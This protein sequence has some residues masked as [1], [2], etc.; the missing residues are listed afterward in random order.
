MHI[1]P[2]QSVL[3]CV[4]FTLRCYCEEIVLSRTGKKTNIMSIFKLGSIF[5]L[6][7]SVCRWKMQVKVS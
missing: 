4:L 1:L 6:C 5:T 7:F 2:T 3:E